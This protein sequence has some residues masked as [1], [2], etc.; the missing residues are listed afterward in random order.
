MSTEESTVVQPRL[1]YEDEQWKGTYIY[2]NQGPGSLSGKTKTWIVRSDYGPLLGQVKWWAPWRKYTFLPCD[3]TVF[4]QVCMR[5]IAQFI[6]D[7][8]EEHKR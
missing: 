2:F 6:E 8:T 4:E 5:E 7:R 3:D 1:R